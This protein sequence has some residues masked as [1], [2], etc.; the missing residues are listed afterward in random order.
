MACT[1]PN[2]P[3]PY[4]AQLAALARLDLG[5]AWL[6]GVCYFNPARLLGLWP[7]ARITGG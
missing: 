6:R 3:N 4:L 7:G 5:D 1:D 2:I